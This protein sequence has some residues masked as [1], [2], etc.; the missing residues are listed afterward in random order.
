MASVLVRVGSAAL[1]SLA[2]TA[3]IAR[4]SRRAGR[5]A[6]LGRL[7]GLGRARGCYYTKAG[8]GDVS[9]PKNWTCKT[10]LVVKQA[11]PAGRGRTAPAVVERPG[12]GVGPHA[13]GAREGVWRAGGDAAAGRP[14]GGNVACPGA[15]GTKR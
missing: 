1:L 5:S 4:G 2:A 12:A 14:Q 7:A 15:A 6:A 9:L 11:D 3:S 10:A 13:E 8:C